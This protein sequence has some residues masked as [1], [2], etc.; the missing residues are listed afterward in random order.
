MLSLPFIVSLVG[1][2]VWGFFSPV[3]AG[4]F[5]IALAT[6]FTLWQLLAARALR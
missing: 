2:T 3:R 6:V 5:F 1:L 4:Y